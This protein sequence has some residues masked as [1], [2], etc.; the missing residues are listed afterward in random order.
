MRSK[1]SR[2][3]IESDDRPTVEFLNKI[4]ICHEVLE[5]AYCF[6]NTSK[7]TKTWYPSETICNEILVVPN[8]PPAQAGCHHRKSLFIQPALHSSPKAG[9]V[10]FASTYFHNGSG[11]IVP[12]VE[13]QPTETDITQ[14]KDLIF[15]NLLKDFPFVSNS[16][17]TNILSLLILPFV[18]KLISGNT[19]IHA[20]MAPTPRTGKTLLCDLMVLIA[21]GHDA[22][23]TSAPTRDEEWC[24]KITSLLRELP[25]FI[26]FDNVTRK[27][28]S[29][30]LS[31]ALTARYYGDRLLGKTKIIKFPVQCTW[32]A[33][34]NNI[35]FSNEIVNRVLPHPL[36]CA[37]ARSVITQT[38]FL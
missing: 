25:T 19:P 11:L 30:E 7:G 6:K 23:K 29:G 3:D 37:N 27:L 20:I 15:N 35:R 21:Q 2:I 17:Q 18:R 16:D 33:T 13:T 12:E 5:R 1:I 14:A 31:L 38:E 8:P 26:Y 28:D 22:L 36:R 32:I 10:D 9:Y 4:Q 24:K 34:G